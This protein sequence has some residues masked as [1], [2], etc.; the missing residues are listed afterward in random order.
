MEHLERYIVDIRKNQS[1]N[2]E[3]REQQQLERKL[4]SHIQN[5]GFIVVPDHITQHNGGNIDISLHRP[6]NAFDQKGFMHRHDYFE[7]LYVYR[8][9]CINLFEH[10]K[11][12]LRHG[13]VLLL[14]PHTLHCPYTLDQDDCLFNICIRKP[15][16]EKS[17]LS[18]LSDNHLFSSFIVDCMYQ[19]NK[20]RDYLFFQN[21][22]QFQVNLIME[23]IITEYFNRDICYQRVIESMLVPLFAQLARIY[24]AHNNSALT[25]GGNNRT[26]ADIV[27]YMNEYS[28]TVTLTSVSHQFGYSPS[29][30]S[31]LIKRYTGKSYTEI[32]QNFKLDKAK[33]YLENSDM[34]VAEIINLVG[35]KDISHFYKIFRTKYV[36]SP[37][38][39]R[40][41]SVRLA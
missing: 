39:Y 2:F 41:E 35:F 6:P 28:S 30:V 19:I 9:Q 31:K 13:D 1:R 7:L 23:S 22:E 36:H 16:L 8:G 38:A 15:L 11:L 4:E 33:Q 10:D 21:D 26:V 3:T 34:S 12:K 40:K 20:A 37:A 32:L 27:A 29:Y 25:E 14:N 17:M 5:V 18:L 24:D